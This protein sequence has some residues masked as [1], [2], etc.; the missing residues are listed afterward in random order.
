METAEST[1]I[2]HVDSQRSPYPVDVPENPPEWTKLESWKC[3]NCPLKE[4][5]TPYCP[6]AVASVS[7]IEHFSKVLS[8]AKV[9][10]EVE[11]PHRK[12]LHK[13]DAQTAVRSLLG[14]I[15]PLSGCPVL[16]RL[17]GMAH[18]HLPF[19][20]LEESIFRTVSAYL[21]RQY[22]FNQKGIET[23]TS[24]ES[25]KDFYMDVQLI[26]TSFFQRIRQAS[27]KD[28]NLNAIVT[29]GSMSMLV[30]LDLEENLN[31]LE[32]LFTEGREPLPHSGQWAGEL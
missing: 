9:H 12:I 23:T 18:F 5:E 2:C 8:T 25:L 11:T 6:A 27:Q 13:T 30:S 29:L 15:M 4:G 1:F 24:I 28:S 7:V 19:S 10:V 32:P 26:N 21:L 22:F 20:T 3:P 17:K 16:S 31:E 14:L